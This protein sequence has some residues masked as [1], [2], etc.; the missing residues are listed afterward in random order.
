MPKLD[1]NRPP[2]DGAPN[3]ELPPKA[4]LP[5]NRDPP[6]AGAGLLP[7]SPP[8]GAGVVDPNKP[9][10]VEPNSPPEGAGAP[11]VEP[12]KAGVGAGEAPNAGAGV[13]APKDEPNEG[14]GAGVPPKLT[15]LPPAAA[16]NVGA[17]GDGELN[18]CTVL[19]PQE[20]VMVGCCCA[21]DSI[22]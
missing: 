7:K 5:P 22:S 11:N 1:P 16:P 12:P 4:E 18:V 17:T 6:G 9:P 10:E 2:G 15:V 21:N 8:E 3:V 20:I 19:V 13:G 14:A